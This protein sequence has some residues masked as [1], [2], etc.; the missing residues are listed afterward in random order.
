M[1]KKNN[2]LLIAGGVAVV[3]YFLLKGNT[4]AAPVVTNQAPASG[5]QVL[6]NGTVLT[7][8][9]DVNVTAQGVPTDYGV[10]I[11]SD[12]IHAAVPSNYAILTQYHPNLLNPKYQLSQN[13]LNQYVANY[14]DIRQGVAT[15]P[16]GLSNANIQKHWTQY[17]V[18]NQ[19][20]F[21]P[22]VPISAPPYIPPPPSPKTTSGSGIWGTLA[23]V[24]TIAAGGILTV[25]SAG[26]LTPLIAAG[27][28]AALTAES[29][30][31]GPGDLL[32]D[33]ELNILVTSSAITKK[34]LPF[35]LE[36]AP[37][38][39]SLIENRIDFLLSQYKD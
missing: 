4:A 7:P 10:N 30:I 2:T 25:A 37:E 8:S 38:L 3:G 28:S 6:S 13:E 36:V 5:S 11:G 9:T 35:Y 16:G 33:E 32:T 17:G 27:T 26:T 31:H 19:R 14:T 39:V 24:A 34:I 21:L 15:W 22:L 23:K 29:A 12:G 1:V 18:P 20:I